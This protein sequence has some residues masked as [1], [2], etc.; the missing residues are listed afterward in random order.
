MWLSGIFYHGVNSLISLWGSAIKSWW[1]H[2]A[3]SWYPSWL[4][5]WG[6]SPF[7]ILVIPNVNIGSDKY[8]FDH[9]MCIEV[10]SVS[11]ATW[12]HLTSYQDGYQLGTVHTHGNFIV[13]LHWETKP[14][15]T[16]TWYPTQSHYPDTQPAIGCRIPGL[17]VTSINFI[18]P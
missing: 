17:D 14:S 8:Q 5:H 1:V 11:F 18:S 6:T 15:S 10:A 3:A 16:M 4:I 9:C 12:R 2:R 13:L 7:P